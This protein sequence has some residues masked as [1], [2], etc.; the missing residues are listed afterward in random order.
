MPEL[1]SLEIFKRY[2]DSTSLKQEIHGVEIRNPEIL[3][4]IS[5]EELNKHLINQEFTGSTRYGKYLFCHLNNGYHLILHFG[6]TGYLEY[7]QENE[8]PYVRVLI[9]FAGGNKLGF[10]DMRKFGKVSLT[11]DIE[12]FIQEKSLGPDALKIDCKTF[13][14][15]FKNRKGQIKPLL[16][17]QKFIAGIGNLY[18]DEILY[19]SG[20]NP[21][22]HADK[23]DVEKLEELYHEM[24]R[25][26]KKAIE[27]QDKPES[28]P[29]S[30]LL[31]HRHP[32]GE[33]P[34][35]DSLEIIKVGG[36]TT[37]FCPDYQKL[38]Q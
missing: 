1:P 8:K 6:M 18:A 19:Q 12:M 24:H 30:F 16:M 36:R 3:V 2:F 31:P 28:L 11:R 4:N 25:V 29:C 13:K 20:I 17:N 32:D 27:Y 38:Y 15:S 7:F 10:V 5:R 14:N 21:T 33:C 26:L 22:S 37:Y 9:E 34:H 35:G 23:L